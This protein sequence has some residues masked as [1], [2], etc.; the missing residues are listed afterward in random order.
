LA[1]PERIKASPMFLHY[2]KIAYRN[3]VKNK[4]SAAINIFG[5]TIGLTSCLLIG[6]YIEQE[7]SYDRFE[8][9]GDRIC[10]IVMEYSFDG[11]G[12]SNK[13]DFTSVRVASVFKRNFPEVEAAVKM[14]KQEMVVRSGE[15]LLSE[16]GFMFADSNFFSVFSFPLLQGD[17]ARAL[18]S[19]KSVVLTRSTAKRYFGDLNPVGRTLLVGSDSSLYQ[20]TGIMAD[21]PASS[22]IK[23]DFLASFS[24][25][26][27]EKEAEDSYWDANYTTY[28][29]VRSEAS[30][31]ALQAKLIPFMEKE[32]A[33]SGAKINFYLEPM[34][35][36]HLH[37]PYSGFEPNSSMDYIYILGAVALVILVIACST[38]VNLSTARS[39]ERAREVGVRKVAGAGRGQLFWQFIGESAALCLVS[40]AC[41]LVIAFSALPYF[42]Q[43]TG[44]EFLGKDLFSV[45]FLGFW[46]AVT[47]GISLAAGAY[48]ALILT[49]YEPSRVLKGSFKNSGS[50]EWLR[51]SLLVFQFSISVFLIIATLV[52]QKQLYFIEH[53]QLGYERDRVLV[54]PMDYRLLPRIPLLKTAFTSNPD[55]LRVSRCSASPVEIASGYNMRSALMPENQ[56]MTVTGNPIDQ[57]Y[58]RTTGLQLIAGGDFTDQDIRDSSDPPV[59]PASKTYHF[60]LNESA[61]RE[62]GWTPEQAIGQKMFLDASRPG[63]VRG[64]VRDFHFESLHSPIRPLVLFTEIRGRALV[65]KLSGKNIPSALS[66][67][68]KTWKSLVPERPFNYRF[69]DDDFNK[70]YTSE[71]R[72]SRIM[73]LFASIAIVLACLGLLGLASCGASQRVKEIGVRK[74][75]GASLQDIVFLLSGG[76]VRLALISLAIAFPVALWGMQRWL[77]QYAYRTN[78]PWGV[79]LGAGAVTLLLV[80]STVA[81][82]ALQ[83][84]RANP[85]KS[86]RAE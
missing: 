76:F 72:L 28:V 73:N 51:K 82:R 4:A 27:I 77:E 66:F 44:K 85:V 41:S 19:P 55:I 22:Q 49:R 30:I 42:N 10:R 1:A 2:V 12:A 46:L 61:A 59:G 5:L 29:L 75:L 38:F 79:F 8:Q 86:L 40:L 21:C 7:L 65:V 67:L 78:L 16:K 47:A 20:I 11:G 83:A 63:I 71:L 39:L 25:L 26:G 69:L 48:P 24:S 6:L 45:P 9:K 62:L 53:K 70:L 56:Q 34:R 54:L 84:A 35:Q 68:E 50:G 58:I 74:A 17:P 14:T 33:G 23:C 18:A 13:G 52:I 15:N 3:L 31:A 37:S 36:I 81:L 57:D 80:I 64:V 32:M 60:I 43:L